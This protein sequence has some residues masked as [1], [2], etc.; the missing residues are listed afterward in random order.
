MV[1]NVLK[2]LNDNHWYVIAVLLC[3]A[4]VLWIY[5]CDSTVPSI[6]DPTKQVNRWEL[7]AEADYLIGQLNAKLVT[8]D[9]QDEVKR[10]LLDQAVMFSQTGTFNPLGL[11][12]L[13]A[14]VGAVSFGLDRNRRYSVIKKTNSTGQTS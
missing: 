3:S 5:G 10:L 2:F 1:K 9:R 12:N 4:L 8:L 11:V 7:E 13:L 14:T 6:I